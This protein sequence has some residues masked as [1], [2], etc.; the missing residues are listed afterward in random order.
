MEAAD[1]GMR[2]DGLAILKWLTDPQ[3]D[4]RDAVI[5]MIME[6]GINHPEEL[7]QVHS[8]YISQ[9]KHDP[10]KGYYYQKN[11]LGSWILVKVV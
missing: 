5:E 7:K 9:R 8:C 11:V 3:K 6:N 4:F 10:A 2:T 1:G